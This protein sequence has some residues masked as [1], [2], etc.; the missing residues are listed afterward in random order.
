VS[1]CRGWS[2]TLIF[3]W[4]FTVA[5]VFSGELPVTYK[6]TELAA[7]SFENWGEVTQ[8]GGNA[9]RAAGKGTSAVL[10]L[11]N[12][13]GGTIRPPQGSIFVIEITYKD[14]TD[15]PVIAEAFGGVGA[16]ESRT[17]LH[18]FG[19]ANDGQWKVASI[20]ASWDLLMLRPGATDLE[21]A[22][23]A[24][25]DLP[26]TQLTVRTARLPEDQVRYEAESRAWVA[27]VQASKI[28]Q[29][30][31]PAAD[32]TPVIPE[33]MKT[34]ALVPYA[35][36]YFEDICTNSAPR[37]GEAGAA[38][39]IR[40]ARNEFEPGTFGI[41]AQDDVNDV[42]FSVSEL[43]GSAGKLAC[44]VRCQ[45]TE[46][47]VIGSKNGLRWSPQRL[48]PM[49]PA[50]LKKGQSGSFRV[51]L[52]TLGE[53]SRPGKYEGVITIRSA[54]SSAT[55]PLKVE[56]LP[57]TLLDMDQAGLRMGG[58]VTGY[59]SA[60][61]LDAM[62][63]HNHNMVNL[64][65][66]GVRP[67]LTVKDGKL[68]LDFYYMDEW[69]RLA[70]E[71]GINTVVYFLGG[72][73]NGYPNTLSAERDLYAALGKS[74]DDF[75]ERMGKPE[76]RGKFLPEIEGLYKDLV[77]GLLD[78]AK[79]KNWPQII[80]TPFDEPAKWANATPFAEKRKYAIGCG[81]W[82]R[83]HFKASC[84]LIHAAHPDAKVYISLHHNYERSVHGYK[85]RVGEVFFSDVD[86]LCTNAIHEDPELG[87]K[88]R[89]LGKEFW[90]YSGGHSRRYGFGFY[91][92]KSDS[93]GFLC[94]AYNWGPRFDMSAGGA[95]EY[96]WYS[97]FTTILT[98]EYEDYREAMDDRRYIETAK[99][100]ARNAGQDIA[101]LLEQ[102]F[103]EV[104]A[105]RGTG[106]RDTVDD[107]WEE[108]SNACKMDQWR[109]KLA[110]KIIE[111]AK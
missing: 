3:I 16:Y 40:M 26:V 106:G 12:W 55:L 99:A 84:G 66:A 100:A 101:P 47:A 45:S 92:G 98:P 4:L 67:G 28:A 64:W 6:L 48:W 44:E 18:R 63:D 27:Q 21:F 39:H 46:F 8:D 82:T 5:N 71:R 95:W 11:P 41:Y 23:R 13:W 76:Q 111:T 78:H 68:E 107:F 54:K 9:F 70:K 96:A 22:V 87:N 2:K 90:Q 93:K 85:G 32:E 37:K 14:V 56:V 50:T 34:N 38:V 109:Q 57:I 24:G 94:W 58:C 79:K 77:K 35:R 59:V 105:D 83:D 52:K 15:T 65:F 103:A 108:G 104:I 25:V 31:Q 53:T 89:A 86:I 49:F 20:P 33:G 10:R 29:V 110:N 102:I 75:F 1:T 80:L 81:P 88:V 62:R 61:E 73:P 51:T 17:E 7:K 43:T 72:N 97:S 60:G 91:F 74:K 19:G 69:M 42:T 30:K 36:P